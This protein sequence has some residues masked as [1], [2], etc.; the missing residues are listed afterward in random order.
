M[1]TE[2][3]A[4]WAAARSDKWR[5]QLAGLEAMLAPIDQPL[6][7]ALALTGPVRIADIGCGGG[8]TTMAVLRRAPAGSVAHGFDLSPALIE[9]ARRRHGAHDAVAFEVADMGTMPPPEL[10]YD[11]LVSRLGVMFFTDPTAA[12]ANLRRWLVPGGRFAFAVW[13]PVDDNAWMTAT[14]AAVADAIDLAPMDLRVPGPFRYGDVGL[15]VSLLVRGG[16]ADVTVTDWREALPIG[17]RLPASDAAQFA[18]AS[19]SSFAELLSGAGA[20]APLRAHRALTARFTAYEQERAVLMP[21]RVHIV[22]GRAV[23][24]SLGRHTGGVGAPP[25]AETEA[26]KS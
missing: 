16:F 22:T 4:D 17:D 24:R 7:E 10:A 25:F 12:F 6:I 1:T 14:R 26:T 20:E 2:P 15:L 5:R 23:E 13:G 18:L 19:F 8:A 3:V 9:A 11:R 21:A